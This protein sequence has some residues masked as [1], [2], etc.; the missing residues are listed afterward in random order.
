MG[1]PAG[2]MGLGGLPPNYVPPNLDPLEKAG[3]AFGEFVGWRM[4]QLRDGYLQS[5]TASYVWVPGIATE[6]K[7][8]DHDGGGLWAFK[9]PAKA[10][11]KLLENGVPSAMGSVWMYGDIVEHSDGY[12]A[13]Y[14]MVRSIDEVHLPRA[15][16][17]RWWEML[18]KS[19]KGD[20]LKALRERYQLTNSQ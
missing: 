15:D 14:A 1:I 2:G 4:W 10:L 5:Y 3:T 13:Q 9:D 6:G 17:H 18:R 7:P 11:H 16:N 19:E 12:R 8:G 20:I